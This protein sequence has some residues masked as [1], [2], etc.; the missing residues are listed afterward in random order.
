MALRNAFQRSSSLLSIRSRASLT[1]RALG[2]R[3]TPGSKAQR[4][5]SQPAW[6][7]G[8]SVC[9]LAF[10]GGLGVYH[11]VGKSA[12]PGITNT[13][14][15]VTQTND[16]CPEV[17]QHALDEAD[18]ESVPMDDEEKEAYFMQQFARYEAL[19]KDGPFIQTV[20]HER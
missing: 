13:D 14:E 8:P 4:Y 15:A 5:T 19:S 12:R 9:L 2:H 18:N 3:Y 17:I 16:V 10:L 1:P 6:K 7:L 11:V 20:P